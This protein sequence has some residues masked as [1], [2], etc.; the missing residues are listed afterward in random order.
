[1]LSDVASLLIGLYATQLAKSNDHSKDLSYGLKR[2]EVLGALINGVSLM[3]LC[4]TLFISCIQRFFKPESIENPQTVLIVA[5]IGL[6]VNILGM[7]LF[8][9]HGHGHGHGHS[10]DHGEEDH[11]GHAHGRESHDFSE[12]NMDTPLIHDHNTNHELL[13]QV[14]HD[15]DD[16][17]IDHPVALGVNVIRVANLMMKSQSDIEK[18]QTKRQNQWNVVESIPLPEHIEQ[19]PKRDL[20]MHGV[21]LHI[22]GDFLGSVGVCVS[23]LFVLFIDQEW[24]IY[25]DPLTSLFI[26]TI[27]VFSSIPLI[28]SA[29]YI[30]LQG[31]P[32]SISVE[33]LKQD[34][35]KIPGVVDVHELHV[36]TLSDSQTVAS[37]HVLVGNTVG[38]VGSRYMNLAVEIKKKLHVYGIHSTTVQPEF[39]DL[40]VF[41]EEVLI[42]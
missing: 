39:V 7:F 25:V 29:S 37:V 12:N 5:V 19:K 4:F 27:I 36:W 20:N 9:D 8:H 30:L 13:L 33:V 38:D 11:T 26:T 28:K 2:A 42:F 31:A 35:R 41:G 21:F 40:D 18:L 6:I 16:E 32:S 22:L 34:I 17:E 3:A 10:H 24:T 15:S 23:T 1:M 14:D